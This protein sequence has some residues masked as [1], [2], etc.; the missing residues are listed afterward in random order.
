[1]RGRGVKD[2]KAKH[3]ESTDLGSGGFTE[4]EL[5]TRELTSNRP[6]HSAYVAVLWL[7]LLVGF[8][9]RRSLTLFPVFGTHSSCWVTSFS[10][11]RRGGA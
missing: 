1:M 11:N 6:E 5:T 2:T 4:I 7:C 8:L 10:L 3:I 9:G